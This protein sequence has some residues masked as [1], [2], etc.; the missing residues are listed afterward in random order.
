MKDLESKR[1]FDGKK[2]PYEPPKATCVRV[3]VEQRLTGCLFS[4][5]RVCGLNE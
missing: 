4:S 1:R 5:I 3:Q 2:R